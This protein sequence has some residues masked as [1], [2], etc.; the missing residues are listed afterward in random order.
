M[1][2]VLLIFGKNNPI[3]YFLTYLKSRRDRAPLR[4][5]EEPNIFFLQN[6]LIRKSENSNEIIA[7]VADFGLA[8]RIPLSSEERLPQV[9]SPYWMSP[10]CLKGEFYN[11]R[12]DT[13]SFGIIL[14]E[15]IGRVD[16]DPDFLPRTENFGVDYLAFSS[17][18]NEACPPN[19][20]KIS[21]KCVTVSIR[22]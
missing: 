11:H 18:V 20:L 8:A 14:C 10:E 22:A 7:V 21:Y 16:A 12:S 9:G 19:F 3:K 6:I 13:F 15:I 5:T 2:P 17:I 4:D 1:N